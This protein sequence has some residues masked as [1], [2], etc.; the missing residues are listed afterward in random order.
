MQFRPIV[1]TLV[2]ILDREKQ[3]VLMIRR[4]ARR[5]DDHY[6]KVNGLG[7]KLNQDESVVDCARREIFEEAGIELNS[8]TLRGTIT[9]SNFGPKLEEW[10]GFIFL[11]DS[12]S[13]IPRTHNEEG[14]LEWVSLSELLETCSPDRIGTES[15]SLPMW[16]GDRY[17]VPLVFDSDP[18][19]F[20]GTMPY[21]GDLPVSWSYERL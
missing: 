14:S 15:Q 8:L 12:W 21:E 10:L 2:Y 16:A 17:L 11:S 4:N 19:V 9:W 7:G 6:G 18:Q 3:K 13:G 5:D 20:H 1:G